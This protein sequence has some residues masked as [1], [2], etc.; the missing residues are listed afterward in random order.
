MANLNVLS[1]RYATSTINDIFSEEG[2]TVA[3]RDLW[4]AVMKAQRELGVD[5]PSETIEKYERTRDDVDLDRIKVIEGVTRHD[6]KAKIEAFTEVAGVESDEQHLHKGMTSRDLTDNVEQVQIREASR[7]IF[8]KYVS[9]L[10]HM[11]DKADEYRD[12]VMVGRTHNQPA[13][14]IVLGKDM[15][16]YAEELVTHLLSFENFITDYR[17]RGIKGP[18]GTQFDM[19]TLL[20]SEEKVEEL[21][22]VVAGHLGFESTL[23]SVGQIY[24]RSLDFDLI[25]GL[26]KLSSSP[27][28]YAINMR[29][30][31][32]NGLV[33]EGFREGQ[34]GSTAM[35]HKM[36]TRSSERINGFATV[37]DGYLTMASISSGRQW[38]GGDVSCSVVRRVMI[39]DSFYVSDGLCETALTVLNEM[40]AFPEVIGDEVDRYLP[41]LATTEILMMAVQSGI[42]R[43]DAHRVIKEYSIDEA[44]K[45]RGGVQP[46]LAHRLARDPLFI[47]AGITERRINDILRDKT[48]FIG[49]SHAQIDRVALVAGELLTTY[50]KEAQYEPGDIL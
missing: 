40:G 44:L 16:T 35:P 12:I 28:N 27:S 4:I 29:L 17:L 23:D 26:V 43:E 11:L 46:N 39:P 20:G 18:M 50:S 1:E 47:G 9:V 2:K 8:G 15:S 24:P 13:Q 32:G 6:V 3:E 42:G 49:N 21:E 7:V 48:H 19:L 30:M 36:N 10:R 38:G 22:R 37:L 5:I 45:M 14:P 34:V 41:F 25:S 31:A 33:T